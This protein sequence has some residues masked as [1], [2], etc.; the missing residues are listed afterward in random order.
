MREHAIPQDVVG[1]KFHIVGNMTLKQFLEVGAGCIVGFGIFSTNLYDIIKWPLIGLAVGIGVLA[2]FV[3]FEERPLDHWLMTFIKILYKPTKFFW[4]K[5]P[6]IPDPFAYKPATEATTVVEVD[7]SPYRRQR[8]K[9]YLV[10]VQA[11]REMDAFEIDEVNRISNIMNTFGTITVTEIEAIK[12]PKIA[13]LK[14]TPHSLTNIGGEEEVVV[15]EVTQ[16]SAVAAP[17]A[18]MPA[19]PPLTPLPLELQPPPVQQVAPTLDPTQVAQKVAIP[20]A[21]TISVAKTQA[22]AEE[23]PTAAATLPE[24]QAV[25]STA[26]AETTA[27]AASQNVAFNTTLPFPAPPTEPNKIVGMVLT[28]NNELVTEAIV[29]IKTSAGSTARAV[30]TNALGQFFVS[31][32]LPN[33]DYV[34][35][36]DKD[37]VSAEPMALSLVG[38]VVPP[39]EIRTA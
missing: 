15:Q 5:E 13:T 12:Q 17:V 23:S 38:Q 7:L 30:K 1:Y 16:V 22:N 11:P 31:T 14:V 35:E 20:D 4:R 19:S 26:I 39:I 6:H 2:A 36:I 29:E 37:N 28:P 27:A 21:P 8:A 18:T 34:I 3:P 32:A 25:Y 9:E 24:S 10:S 33:G